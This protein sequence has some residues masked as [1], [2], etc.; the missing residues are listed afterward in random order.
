MATLISLSPELL[1]LILS[2]LS[3]QDIAAA[4]QTH[5]RFCN[6]QAFLLFEDAKHEHRAL[7]WAS[8]RG[9]CALALASITACQSL[10]QPLAG[11]FDDWG[12][13]PLILAVQWGHL[14]TT[15]LLLNAGFHPD[16]TWDSD[17][18]PLHY[19]VKAGSYKIWQCLLQE[20]ADQNVADQHGATPLHFA[21][22]AASADIVEILLLFGAN[23]DAIDNDGA[24]PLIEAARCGNAAAAYA[25]SSHTFNMLAR[26]SFRSTAM[27]YAAAAGDVSVIRQLLSVGAEPNTPNLDL[28]TPLHLAAQH[29]NINALHVLIDGSATVDSRDHMSETPL[30]KASH[31]GSTVCEWA[32]LDRGADCNAVT[33]SGM[34]PLMY[35][36][37][38]RDPGAARELLERSANASKKSHKG[39]TAYTYAAIVENIETARLL[40]H[41]TSSSRVSRAASRHHRLMECLIM[42]SASIPYLDDNGKA[43]LYI[44]ASISSATDIIA[45]LLPAISIKKIDSFSMLMHTTSQGNSYLV[46][47][48]LQ[49]RS[50]L[51][52]AGGMRGETALHY[53]ALHNDTGLASVL[54]VRGSDP[55]AEGS[56]GSTPLHWAARAG[57]DDRKITQPSRRGGSIFVSS[58]RPLSE[59]MYYQQTVTSSSAK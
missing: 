4:I 48:L 34:T 54:L 16:E 58:R 27:A 8:T 19:A 5:S 22:Q 30:H 49:Y 46:D 52:P 12:Q 47:L 13:S 11:I 29:G 35:A 17:M 37:K 32:L 6:F 56:T 28:A 53:A 36:A 23:A 9:N 1:S 40:Y 41:Y 25:L 45:A 14:L 21:A 50:R 18:S 55:N 43:R 44:T 33:Q 26:N 42:L 10:Q 2:Y 57:H 15:D 39:F 51:S 20:K 31:A 24:T 38:Q 3:V 7:L 59:A